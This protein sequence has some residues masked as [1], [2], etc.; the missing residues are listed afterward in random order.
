MKRTDLRQWRFLFLLGA[1]LLLLV[2][3][4]I[5]FGMRVRYWVFDLLYSLILIATAY[6]F[7]G[8][9]QRT[10]RLVV[11]VSLVLAL[12]WGTQVLAGQPFAWGL[13]VRYLSGILF[14]SYAVGAIVRALF[15]SAT[16]TLDSV[17][18]SLAGYLLLG[19]IWAMVFSLVH[20]ATPTAFDLGKIWA[21]ETGLT[22]ERLPLFNYYSFVTLTT[23]GYGDIT[24]LSQTARTL[25]WTAAVSGQFYIATL[26]AWI[27]GK[28]GRMA[29]AERS[30]SQ[31]RKL[32][33]ADS[34]QEP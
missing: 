9:N 21:A 25:S 20:I 30:D 14:L 19:M 27:V 3:E 29:S 12:T 31:S 6:A 8:G 26:V 7:T 5:V 4:P 32:P 1:L 18:G 24:P 15:A 13:A 17:F 10:L 11:G 28:T 2:G 16:I 33:P 23:L 22:H 34:E